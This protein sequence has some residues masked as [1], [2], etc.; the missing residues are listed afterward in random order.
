MSEPTVTDFAAALARVPQLAERL[1]RALELQSTA[2]APALIEPLPQ[3]IRS[4]IHRLMAVLALARISHEEDRS[5]FRRDEPVVSRP[6][7]QRARIPQPI[8]RRI[9]LWKSINRG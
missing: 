1:E 5:G 9:G 4:S 6:H 7:L 8:E 3:G 2:A